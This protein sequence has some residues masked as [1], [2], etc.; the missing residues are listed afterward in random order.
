ML[1]PIGDDAA[2]AAVIIATLDNPSLRK[3]LVERGM[4]LSAEQAPDCYERLIPVANA[5]NTSPG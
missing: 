3:P 4:W 5:P 1:V 2:L